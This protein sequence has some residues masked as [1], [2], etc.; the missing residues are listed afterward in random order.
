MAAD[1]NKR[2]EKYMSTKRD[3]KFGTMC[4][5]FGWMGSAAWMKLMPFLMF[6]LLLTLDVSQASASDLTCCQWR[7]NRAVLLHA[8]PLL[9]RILRSLA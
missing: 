5:S 1:K 3:S 7:P 9:P 4:S 2:K 8:S 6:T